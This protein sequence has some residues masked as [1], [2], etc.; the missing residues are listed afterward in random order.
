MTCG[1]ETRLELRAFG[2]GRLPN[3]PQ[4]GEVDVLLVKKDDSLAPEQGWR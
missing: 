4:G 1:G 3:V 2:Q